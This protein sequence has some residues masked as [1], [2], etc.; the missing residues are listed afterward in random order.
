[1]PLSRTRDR[2]RKRIERGTVLPS[3][4]DRFHA[5]PLYK[6][7]EVLAEI[8]LHPNE[9]PVSPRHRIAAVKELNLM[10]HVYQE[11]RSYQDNRQ[12]NIIIQGESAKGQ[13]ESMLKGKVPEL[14]ENGE[15]E[16]PQDVVS[17]E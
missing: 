17:N 2:L 15:K 4:T 10:E 12:Y 7:K 1:M 6:R 11:D 8:A 13:L 5:L 9:T 3:P 16:S 14:Q